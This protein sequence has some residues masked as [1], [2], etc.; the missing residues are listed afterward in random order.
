MERTAELSEAQQL[1]ALYSVAT[2]VNQSLDIEFV[3]RNVM[4]KIQEIFAFDAA[5]IYLLDRDG[6]ELCLL[7]H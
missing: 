7:A 3:L 4:R 6:K 5:R 1:S 2:L